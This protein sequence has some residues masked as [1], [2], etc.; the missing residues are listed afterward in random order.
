MADLKIA[1]FKALGSM[2][3]NPDDRLN[4]LIFRRASIGRVPAYTGGY[5]RDVNLIP[6][7]AI[8]TRAQ[9]A[10]YSSPDSLKVQYGIYSVGVVV[11]MRLRLWGKER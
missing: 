7:L 4:L 6:H 2:G 3:A 10:V 9:L 11:F 1:R 8:A 5:A